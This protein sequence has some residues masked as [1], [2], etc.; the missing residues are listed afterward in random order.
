MTWW[1]FDAPF[2][3]AADIQAGSDQQLL[4]YHVVYCYGDLI[5][6]KLL[7]HFVVIASRNS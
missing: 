1:L 5:L 3:I 4:E 6:F 7:E 2:Q